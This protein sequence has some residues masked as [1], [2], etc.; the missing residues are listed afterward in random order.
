MNTEDDEVRYNVCLTSDTCPDAAQV[1]LSGLQRL[2]EWVENGTLFGHVTPQ[3]P[4]G[5]ETFRLLP[6]LRK[7]ILGPWAGC[8]AQS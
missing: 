7:V 5:F 3:G 1:K 6:M 4:S 2:E 8:T